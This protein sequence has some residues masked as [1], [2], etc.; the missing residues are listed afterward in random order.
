MQIERESTNHGLI[1]VD[2]ELWVRALSAH[3]GRCLLT[4]DPVRPGDRVYVP[5]KT[6][7]H[8]WQR[9]LASAVEERLGPYRD[10]PPLA[11]PRSSSTPSASRPVSVRT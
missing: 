4:G 2:G 3:Y 6:G 1:T 11:S 10:G 7:R 9:I 5:Q 8:R